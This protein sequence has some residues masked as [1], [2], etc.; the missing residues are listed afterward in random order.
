MHAPLPAAV[1]FTPL[2]VSRTSS[3]AP[4]SPPSKVERLLRDTLRRDRAASTSRTAT[5]VSPPPYYAHDVFIAD[6]CSQDED[7][8]DDDIA[9][10][11][12]PYQL[13]RASSHRASPAPAALALHAPPSPSPQSRAQ[14]PPRSPM[15][16]HRPSYSMSSAP[17]LKHPT[18]LRPSSSLREASPAP[19]MPHEVA[20]RSRLQGMLD[21]HPPAVSS[22][23]QRALRA[24]SGPNYGSARR[25]HSRARSVS[26]RTDGDAAWWGGAPGFATQPTSPTTDMSHSQGSPSLES[27]G[28]FPTPP[29]TPPSPSLNIA[30]EPRPSFDARTASQLCRNAPGL[31]SFKDVE[32]L[33]AP[34]DMDMDDLDADKEATPSKG[35]RWWDLYSWSPFRR[36]SGVSSSA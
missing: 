5:P 25:S 30:L 36:S 34:P 27:L 15:S 17:V 4:R 16:G 19:L 22:N 20:L 32:G 10:P 11:Q 6:C 33:G 2:P 9:M 31:V 1:L 3:P 35:G 29:S 13:R 28:F 14:R 7:D 18:P 23:A 21:A 24:V 26:S 12:Q 8:D